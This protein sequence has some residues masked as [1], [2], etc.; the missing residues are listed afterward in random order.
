MGLQR[1]KIAEIGNFW[2]KFAQKGYTLLSDFFYKIWPGEGVPGSH[3]RAKFHHCG[4]E[5][6]R[7]QPPKSPK[8][9]FFVI[10][11]P[12]RGIPLKQAIFTKFGLGEGVPGSHPHAKFHH[13]GL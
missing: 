1:P 2:Y 4:L 9:V 5:N 10:N 8:L 11:L 7:I 6:V 3:P 13:C 12:K